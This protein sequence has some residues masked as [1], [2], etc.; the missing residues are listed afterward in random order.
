MA[1]N[2]EKSIPERSLISGFRRKILRWYN[3]GRRTYP[4][5]NTTDPYRILI[6]EMML[7]R[8]KAD[9]VV[10]VYE[11]FFTSFSSPESIGKCSDSRIERMLKPLGLRW[12]AK[13]FKKASQVLL[14]TFGGKVPDTR[15]ELKTLPGVG[16][17][18]AGM[19][20]ST[21]F[22]KRE[23]AVD[24]N[25]VRVFRRYFGI[26]TSREGRRDAHVTE[27]ARIYSSSRNPGR[28]NIALIDF[29]GTICLPRKPLCNSC[30]LRRKCDYFVNH[31]NQENK[32]E[33]ASRKSTGHNVR[34]GKEYV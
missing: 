26:S 33:A 17:Y 24:S 28:A 10:S 1:G 23:W 31:D 9:Q 27:M 12:R 25:V 29:T 11:E 13:N 22:C 32:S 14:H 30:S 16:D 6:A 3:T 7:Q 15:K 18:V 20:L 8:T 2:T 5:R 19:V 4:W 34:G 21:A